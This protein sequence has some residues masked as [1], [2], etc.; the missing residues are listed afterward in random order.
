MRQRTAPSKGLRYLNYEVWG[1][2]SVSGFVRMTWGVESVGAWTLEVLKPT[3]G[4]ICRRL[5][6]QACK[7][8]PL[9]TH[10]YQWGPCPK[11]L[12]GGDR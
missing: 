5:K 3:T 1:A 4:E 11:L 2:C 6:S 7:I 8:R 12:V 9:A 10:F